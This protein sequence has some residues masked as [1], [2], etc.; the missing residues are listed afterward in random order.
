MLMKI[1]LRRI[2]SENKTIDTEARD[3]SGLLLEL[4][5]NPETVIVRQNSGIRTFDSVLKK[6]D[7]IEIIPVVS[8][9]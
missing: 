5:I 7:E 3:I 6:G 4:G 8:G 9:G 2:G 1:E